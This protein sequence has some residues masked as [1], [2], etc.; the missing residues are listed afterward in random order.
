MNMDIRKMGKD[1]LELLSFT[2]IAYEIIKQD[3]EP[4]TTVVLFKEICGLL[5]MSDSEYEAL[6]ADFFTSLTTDKRFILLNSVNWDLRENHVVNIIVDESEDD[7]E[8]TLDEETGEDEEPKETEDDYDLDEDGIN[9]LG[10][11]EIIDEDEEFEDIDDL[12]IVDE[13]AE[14]EE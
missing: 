3:K 2:D 10:D 4:K 11:D 13:D 6:V 7:Y 5:E 1:E 12:E 8:D 9:D 14:L